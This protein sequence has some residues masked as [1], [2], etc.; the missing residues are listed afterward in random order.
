[1]TSTASSSISIRSSGAGQRSPRTC[2]FRFSPVPTPR[3]KR[4]GIIAAEVAAAWATIA[5]CIRMIGAVTPVPSR[6]RSV[7]W[8]IAPITLQTNG[9]WPCASI[10]GW[11]WSEMSANSN[12]AS[13]RVPREANE[14]VRGV[15][16]GRECVADLGHRSVS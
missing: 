14:V 16:L 8:A 6:S 15:I 13:S 4:P 7:A 10:H 12:P 2:S 11:K 3:K 5:G 1:M 9:L